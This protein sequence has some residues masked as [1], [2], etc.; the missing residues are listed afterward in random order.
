MLKIYAVCGNGLGSSLF[1]AQNIQELLDEHNI[2]GDVEATDLTSAHSLVGD[3]FLG[4]AN[5]VGQLSDDKNVIGLTNLLSK[6]ELITKLLPL[7]K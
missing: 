7:L 4:D 6:D 5:I 1:V 3:Y 2:K